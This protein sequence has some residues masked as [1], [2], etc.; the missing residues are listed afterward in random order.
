MHAV[1][2][3]LTIFTARYY[4]STVLAMALCLSVCPSIRHKSEFY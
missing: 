1:V 3:V 2:S 4:A